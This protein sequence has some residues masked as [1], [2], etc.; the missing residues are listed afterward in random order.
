MIIQL[1]DAD[2][3]DL[4]R[5]TTCLGILVLVARAR[6]EQL[7]SGTCVGILS[8]RKLAL[9]LLLKQPSSLHARACPLPAS[10]GYPGG[11]P[12]ALYLT[13]EEVKQICAVQSYYPAN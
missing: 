7:R 3:V 4:T 13:V 11:S 1:V 5:S 2:P 6:G 12:N 8:T 10:D 9:G